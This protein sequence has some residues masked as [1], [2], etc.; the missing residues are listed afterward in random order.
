MIQVKEMMQDNDLKNSKSKDK[1]SRSRSQSMNEQSHYKQ[2]KTKTRQS[3]NVKSHIFNVIGSTEEFEERDLN[4]GGDSGTLPLC[5]KCKFHHY[6]P[7]TVMR[8]AEGI[9]SSGSDYCWSFAATNNQ[10]THL[11][12]NVGIKGIAFERRGR[13]AKGGCKTL[14]WLDFQGVWNMLE[15]V[16]YYLKLPQE[17]SRVHNTFHV[18]NLKKCYSDDPLVVPLEGFQVDNKLHFFEEPVEIMDREIM[19]PRKAPRTRTTPATTTNTTSVTNAQLQAMIDQGVAAALATRDANRSTNGE[20]SHN[21]GTGVRRTERVARECTYQDFMKCQPLFFKGTE[22]VVKLTQWFE[23]M[24]TV[25]CISNCT[26][27]NQI[28][29]ST[30][31]LLGVAL[32]WWNSHVRTVGHDVAYAMTW[33]DLKKKM[34]DKYYPRSEIKKLEVEM[35]SK[36]SDK[37]EKYVG[38]LPDMIH[39]SVMASRPKTMQDAIEMATELMDK[40][41]STPTERQAEN[42]RKLDNNNQAQQQS[43]KRQNVAQAY[44]AGTGTEGAD[45]QG[46]VRARVLKPTFSSKKGKPSSLNRTNH[47]SSTTNNQLRASSN[48]SRGKAS[49]RRESCV[50]DVR[51]KIHLRIIKEDHFRE[52]NARGNLEMSRGQ[53]DFKI[54]NTLRNKML[55]M[56]A[57]VEW[58][59]TVMKNKSCFVQE[60]RFH[61]LMDDVDDS[62]ENDLALNVDHVFEADE[63]DAFD[64]F[65]DEDEYHEV[66][67]MQTDEQHNYVVDSDADYTSNSNIIPYD[68]Y[69]EDNEDHVVQRNVSSVRNDALMSILDEM[70]EQGVQSR[71]VNDSVTSELARYK[72]LVGEYEKRAKFKLTDRERKIDEQMR[73]IISD[74][75]RKEI[76]LIKNLNFPFS[77]NTP[78]L[79]AVTIISQQTEEVTLLKKWILNKGRQFL[80]ECLDIKKLKDKMEDRLYK[81]DQS[82]SN[83]FHMLS[84]PKSFILKAQDDGLGPIY[85]SIGQFVILTLSCLQKSILALFRDNKGTDILKVVEAPICTQYRMMNDKSSSNMLAVQSFQVPKSWSFLMKFEKDHLAHPD[86]LEKQKVHPPSKSENTKWKFFIPSHGSVTPLNNLRVNE[87]VPSATEINAQVVPPGTSLSTTIAQ[88]APSTSASSSTS[89]TQHTSPTSRN[90]ENPLT[91]TPNQSTIYQAKPTKKHFEAIKRVF[92]YLKG[93]INMGLW[94]PKDNAMSLK[95]MQ[96]RIM[97]M[98]RSRRSTSGMLIFLGDRLLAGHQRSKEYAISTTEAEYIAMSGCC[99]Q[100]LWMRSQ[101][102]D[103]GFDFNK[104]PLYCD[105]KS[106]IALCCNNVQHSRSKHID[107]RHHFIR[108]QVENRVVEL[109]FVETNYQLADN[110]HSTKA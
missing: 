14:D 45:Q 103:Y 28:K 86:N 85:S 42:K 25:F 9:G 91:K 31:T 5:N 75:N 18:S 59:S 95:L 4:I 83:M 89:D 74:R 84:K 71:L 17:L 3:I 6:G 63:C 7:C 96:M 48:A 97:R 51:G 68:Q 90:A 54:Q 62:P 33:T 19:P 37:I 49:S 64:S 11:L 24:E 81:Q 23:R 36:E 93:T 87:P 88:D 69:M 104:I 72:E 78:F 20:D 35:F 100:I 29:F 27:E 55:L 76:V 70:H 107:I 30:C 10:R 101:L 41:I 77:T 43:P 39:G 80:E 99:A 56:Q 1:G 61:C 109:Y 8:N 50:Q 94:Y 22:G 40:K 38:G 15:S 92:R 12:T 65:V 110:S 13:L 79:L 46:P 57:H 2:D 98:S 105:N 82:V 47:T 34:T 58:C 108:E 32:T 60:N 67:E 44:A 16:C 73:I 53:S 66:H 106:A 102:K 52:N 21:S 26:M